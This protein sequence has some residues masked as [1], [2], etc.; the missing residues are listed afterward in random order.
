MDRGK[1]VGILSLRPKKVKLTPL[2]E[3][4][5]LAQITSGCQA[6][7]WERCARQSSA[8][9]PRADHAIVPTGFRRHYSRIRGADLGPR[10]LSPRMGAEGRSLGREPQDQDRHSIFP[11]SQPAGCGPLPS[12][13]RR[14]GTA[15]GGRLRG[16]WNTGVVRRT[17]P[18]AHAPG[19]GMSPLRGCDGATSPRSY[20]PAARQIQRLASGQGKCVRARRFTRPRRGR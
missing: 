10:L 13:R 3:N 1:F 18:G 17:I 16:N 4:S 8:W 19:Y 6:G 12:P 2:I 11:A 14:E 15:A 7:N 5:R 9:L 20:L